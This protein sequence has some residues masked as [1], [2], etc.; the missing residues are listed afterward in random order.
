MLQIL[1]HKLKESAVSVLPVAAIVLLLNLTPLVNFTTTETIVFSI[2]SLLL[3]LGIALFNLGADMA[4]TPMGEQVGSGLPKSGKISTLLLVCFIMGVCVT[5]AEPDLSVLA[6]QVKDVLNGTTLIVTI[7]FG[8]GVF[9][10]LGVL[11]VVFRLNLSNLMTFFYLLLF[12]LAALLLENGHSAFLPLAFDS[13]GVTTGPITVPFIMSLGVGVSAALGDKHDRESSFGFIALCSIGPILA[14]MF[15][16]L[17]TT[18]SIDYKL[19]DYTMYTDSSSIFNTLF[20]TCGEVALA[21]LPIVVFFFVLQWLVLKLPKKR[22]LQIV[23]GVFYTFFGLVIF[24]AAVSIGFVPLGYKMGAQLA[25]QDPVFLV[26]F[27]FLL[28]LTVVLAEPAIHVLNKQV[29][30]VTGGAVKKRSMLIALSAGVGV[31]IALSVIRAMFDF[32]ILYYLVPGYFLSL[33]L[34]FFVPKLYTAIA[35]DS[36]G[37]A[38]GPLTSSFILPFL[39]GVCAVLQGESNIM[40]DALG[41]VSMVAMTPLISIQ[42]LG[43][44]AVATKHL[45]EKIAMKRIL[46]ADDEQI[47]DFM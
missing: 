18:G 33:G 27:A 1:F 34:S 10:I 46:S 28:G 37:V 36:G 41:V 47:I 23:V 22:I 19:P 13:G 9:L 26:L 42:S 5:V 32:S 4:M 21:L 12:A 35:F 25:E 45:R 31:A 44:K 2:C 3:V 8:V 11:R 39:I 6:S 15:L 20:H 38:S 43:F 17:F 16:G 29:E 7:G 40:L 24:L 14:V 30:S